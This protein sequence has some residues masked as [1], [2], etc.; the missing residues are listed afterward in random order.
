MGQ[1]QDSCCS[2]RKA[3]REKL[4]VRNGRVRQDIW[5]V[6][7]LGCFVFDAGCHVVAVVGRDCFLLSNFLLSKTVWDK[8]CEL[9]FS[10]ILAR[11]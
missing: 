2:P 5:Q 4:R 9:N 6:D 1:T 7:K 3:S 10:D 8:Q 11:S